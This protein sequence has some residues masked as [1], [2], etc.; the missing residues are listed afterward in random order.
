MAVVAAVEPRRRSAT[1]TI[2]GFGLPRMR[3]GARPVTAWQAA[4]MAAMSGISPR[5][6]MQVRSG[7]VA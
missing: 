1:S 7:W 5:W 6:V 4:M 3:S 2:S